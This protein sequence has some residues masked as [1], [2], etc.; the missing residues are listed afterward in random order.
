MWDN[1]AIVGLCERI[2][3]YARL[4]ILDNRGTGMSDP[5]AEAPTLEQRMDDIR[6][7]MDAAGSSRA[8][9]MG[10]SEGVPLCILFAA[11]FPQRC[12]ALVLIGGLPL[13]RSAAVA[14]Q[15]LDPAGRRVDRLHRRARFDDWRVTPDAQPTVHL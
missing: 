13:N 14:H 2:T 8:A 12:A 7:V 6:A 15:R 4:I 5:V 10:V 11:A 3:R 1:P 9:L